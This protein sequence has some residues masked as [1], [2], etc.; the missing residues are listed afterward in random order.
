ML[1]TEGRVEHDTD[2]SVT[3]CKQL[4]DFTRTSSCA[5]VTPA[6]DE[7]QTDNDELLSA[8]HI[9]WLSM[10][11]DQ[12]D[13]NA[14]DADAPTGASASF[15]ALFAEWI[16]REDERRYVTDHGSDTDSSEAASSATDGSDTVD[17][18]HPD[19]DVCSTDLSV[20]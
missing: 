9:H 15:D 16:D 18:Y 3:R 14:N 8:M 6:A 4:A 12:R 13:R 1:A 2:Q 20:E 10:E 11:E 7:K 5:T 19:D 17:A